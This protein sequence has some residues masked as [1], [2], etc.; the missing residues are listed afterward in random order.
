MSSSGFF[1]PEILRFYYFYFVL[2]SIL[3][4][5][6]PRYSYGRVFDFKNEFVSSY[7]IGTGGVTF[8]GR[9]AFEGAS[10]ASI[11]YE[12]KVQYIFSGEMGFAFRKGRMGLRAGVELIRPKEIAENKATDSQRVK[13]FTLNSAILAVTPT[14]TI[15]FEF[16]SNARSRFFSAIAA[17]A[18]TI[19]LD[20]TYT[21][22]DEGTTTYGVTDFIEASSAK[23]IAKTLRVGFETLFVDKV[24]FNIEIGYRLLSA[25]T[26][27]HQRPAVTMIGVVAKGDPVLNRDG[28]SRALSLN[29]AFMAAGFRFYF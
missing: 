8:L 15:E 19:T 7:L 21:M 17:G 16:W 6:W 24:T 23:A 27:V 11:S 14:A 3:T 4:L 12:D 1:R 5:I 2:V 18:S 10:T 26:F 22:T 13:M 9:Q 28:T 20:N 25:A 29:G